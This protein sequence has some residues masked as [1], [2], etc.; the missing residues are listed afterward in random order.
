VL[1]DAAGQVTA[2][3]VTAEPGTV[4][5]AEPLA[6]AAGDASLLLAL[7][8]AFAGGLI[9]NLMPCVFPVLSMKALALSAHR[10]QGNTARLSGLAYGAGTVLSFVA[11]AG[12]LL[13][14][15]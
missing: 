12:V 13:A 11:L 7:I 1:K 15:R 14:F 3:D 6:S 2:L 5:P 10:E 9:L 4:A 8:L